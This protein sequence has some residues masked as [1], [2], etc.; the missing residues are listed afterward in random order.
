MAVG[1]VGTVGV[2]WQWGWWDCMYDVAVG[3]VGTVGVVVGLVGTV[4]AVW[5]RVWW[6]SGCVDDGDMMKT[7]DVVGTMDVV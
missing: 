3:L 6:D 5:Q 1:L 4:D 7:M 2:V